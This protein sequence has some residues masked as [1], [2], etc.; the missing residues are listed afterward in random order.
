MCIHIYIY[1]D[2]CT[3]LQ[4]VDPSSGSQRR[5]VDLY[6]YIHTSYR[7]MHACMHAHTR[8]PSIRGI[9]LT[10]APRCTHSQSVDPLDLSGL[11]VAE[12]FTVIGHFLTS[13]LCLGF[14]LCYWFW[15]FVDKNLGEFFRRFSPRSARFFRKSKKKEFRPFQGFFRFSFR[16]YSGT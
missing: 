11:S 7:Y 5:S 14:L 3:Y 12:F 2:T 9:S 16:P 6:I 10:V 8:S 1:T 13:F 4:S 15:Y